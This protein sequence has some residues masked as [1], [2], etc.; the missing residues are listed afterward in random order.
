MA[1]GGRGRG[2]PSEPAA[3]RDSGSG[4]C[5]GGPP[6]R[7]RTPGPT[8]APAV[9]P[10][11]ATAARGQSRCPVGGQGVTAGPPWGDKLW[12]GAGRISPHGPRSEAARCG[13]D[14]VV[15]PRPG[16]YGVSPCG[17]KVLPWAGR[18]SVPPPRGL[19]EPPSGRGI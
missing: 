11:G 12:R 16:G 19:R 17:D 8:P 7:P 3:P 2:R 9:P 4:E 18:G 13:V 10:R 15:S 5:R 14:G 6:D 1:A